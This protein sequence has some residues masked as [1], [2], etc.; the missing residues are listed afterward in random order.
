MANILV[1]DD[2]KLMIELLSEIFLDEG[3][4]VRF[5]TNGKTCLD[6]IAREMPDIV[7]LDMSMPEM[8]G[9]EVARRLRAEAA[10][11]ALPVVAVT[12]MD[13]A[14]D[15]DAAYDAGCSAF[16]SKPLQVAHV[17]EVVRG[18]IPRQG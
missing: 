7:V 6:E 15:Y 16:V 17:V 8:D 5:A 13:T 18:F 3:F 12:S 2:D 1:V 4:D 9:Y 14:A 10:T 11:K